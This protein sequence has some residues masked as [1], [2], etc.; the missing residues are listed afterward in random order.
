MG[1]QVTHTSQGPMR[2]QYVFHM[3]KYCNL[4]GRFLFIISGD[5]VSYFLAV[6]M[7][8]SKIGTLTKNLIGLGR[9]TFSSKGPMR[10]QYVFLTAKYSNCMDSSYFN[11]YFYR[12]SLSVPLNDYAC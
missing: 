9:V 8:I 3:A 12:F 11:Y 1:R 10:G 4:Y 7:L 6:I 2:G 5:S